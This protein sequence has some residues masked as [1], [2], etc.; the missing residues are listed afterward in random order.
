MPVALM[1]DT[2]DDRALVTLLNDRGGNRS[3]WHCQ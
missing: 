1:D 3:A 2:M